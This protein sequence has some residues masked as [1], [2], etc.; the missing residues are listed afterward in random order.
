MKLGLV[1]IASLVVVGCAGS[2]GVTGGTDGGFSGSWVGTWQGEGNYTDS[3]NLYV[4]VSSS[5]HVTGNMSDEADSTGRRA[6]V[7]TVSGTI[8]SQGKANLQLNV[9]GYYVADVTGPFT[10][11]TGPS[12]V[13]NLVESGVNGGNAN[14]QWNLTPGYT[15]TPKAHSH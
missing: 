12:L 6:T 1:V 7:G 8:D 2:G 14:V 13:G 3:G 5:G 10:A 11:E 4:V 15:F 9:P